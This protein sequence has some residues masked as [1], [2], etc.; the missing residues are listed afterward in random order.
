[1]ERGARQEFSIEETKATPGYL[2]GPIQEGEWA[3]LLG[4]YRVPQLC[5]VEIIITIESQQPKWLKGD[6]H[7][8]TVHSDGTYTIEEVLSLCTEKGLD[9]VAL[10]DHNTI[11]QNQHIPH[12]HSITMIPGIELTTNFGHCNFLGSDDPISDFRA[13]SNEEVRSIINEAKKNGAKTV[14]NHPHCPDCGWHWE[15]EM[16]FDWIE[17]WNGPWRKAN[18]DTVQWWHDQLCHGKRITA[19]GGSDTHRPHQYIQHGMPTTWVFSQSK[20]MASIF[21]GINH[22]HVT[23]SYLPSGPFITIS[24]DDYMTGDVVIMNDD[25]VQATI[26]IVNIAE[27]DHIKVISD[28]GIEQ[29]FKH[30]GEPTIEFTVQVEMQQ[31]LRVEVWRYFKEVNQLLMAAMSNPLYFERNK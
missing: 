25:T 22:G 3:V 26:R 11:S 20:S 19:I 27:G 8:H 10:T 31:F 14:L 6:L 9:F 24:S 4:N 21:K 2:P 5:E 15:Y 12:N 13:T 18:E 17:V 16:G 30:N 28:I 1:M 7:N 29:N 23:L